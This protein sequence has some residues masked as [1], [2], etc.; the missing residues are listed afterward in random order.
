MSPE[1]GR[2]VLVDHVAEDQHLAVA[3]HVG[4]HPVEGAPVDAQAQV[5]LFLRRESADRR[6][7]ERQV[8]VGAQ[9]KLLVVIQQVQAA[10]EVGEQHR[11]GLDPLFV[12]QILQSLFADLIRRHAVHAVG[13]RLQIQLFQLVVRESQKIAVLSGH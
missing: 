8:L 5:A 12:G 7:V 13:F 2:S 3:E 4:R 6:A 1:Y 11:D 9:Q 10:F